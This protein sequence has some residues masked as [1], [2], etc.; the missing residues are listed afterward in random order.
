MKLL[1]I[2]NK[3]I[4]NFLAKNK[5]NPQRDYGSLA[6]RGIYKL[7]WKKEKPQEGT[8]TLYAYVLLWSYRSRAR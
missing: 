1:G 5:N 3:K 4:K 8:V 7:G 2:K 6:N